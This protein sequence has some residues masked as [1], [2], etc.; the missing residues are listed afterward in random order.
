[1]NVLL[2][3]VDGTLTLPRQP[4]SPEFA[5]FFDA[6]CRQN[7][8]FLISGSD[9][10]KI[11]EQIPE[12]TINACAGVFGASGAEYYEK[13]LQVY[14]K[15]HTFPDELVQ[16]CSDFV[17]QSPYPF[18]AGNHLEYRPGMLNISVVGRN[19]TVAQR[20]AYHV[21]D[22]TT[23]ERRIFADKLN[24]LDLGYEV[25]CGGEI[26]L[27]IVPAGWNKSVAKREVLGRF[28]AARLVFFGDG[29]REGGND[30]PL[31]EALDDGSGLHKSFKVDNFQDTWKMLL[32]FEE[33]R[34][35]RKAA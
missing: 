25:S 28:P 23:N 21:W 2:F 9:I 17:D 4:I 5:P 8:V 15:Q 3:D 13:S 26:S 32:H 20:S 22:Q 7:P 31:A 35:N 34:K 1:M 33:I 24:A 6:F 14:S 10:S 12:A 27:D 18:R 29:I 19:A 11:R 30:L 16:L